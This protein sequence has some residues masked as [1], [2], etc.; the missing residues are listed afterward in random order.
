[1]DLR[2]TCQSFAA[3]MYWYVYNN[4]SIAFHISYYI[5]PIKIAFIFF[6][7]KINTTIH[8]YLADLYTIHGLPWAR[9]QSRVEPGSA[10]IGEAEAKLSFRI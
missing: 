7:F 2:L 4:L 9:P 6:F 5:V 10:W 8:T 3:R 1:M